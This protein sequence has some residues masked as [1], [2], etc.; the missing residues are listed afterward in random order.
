MENI[1][2]IILYSENFQANDQLVSFARELGFDN[3]KDIKCRTNKK[4]INFIKRHLEQ[5]YEKNIHSDIQ[6]INKNVASNGFAY[7]KTIN[8]NK[9]W[10]IIHHYKR[11]LSMY[12]NFEQIA[13]LNKFNQDNNILELS[14][15]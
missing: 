6:N 7:I 10:A 14:L 9:K 4:F 2:E 12:S 5:N 15:V 11:D 3:I 1:K 8:T 13:Y